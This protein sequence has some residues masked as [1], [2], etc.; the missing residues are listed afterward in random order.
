MA[1]KFKIFSDI[2]DDDIE[3]PKVCYMYFEVDEKEFIIMG[4]FSTYELAYKYARRVHMGCVDRIIIV[5]G[6][7]LSQKIYILRKYPK[8]DIVDI[9]WTHTG[10]YCDIVVGLTNLGGYI[11][12]NINALEYHE[13]GWEN[14]GKYPDRFK[15]IIDEKFTFTKINP[16]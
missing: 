4:L 16:V 3:I 8:K 11:S 14:F 9:V 13:N 12:N 5:P 7:D 15:E 10:E 2:S 6:L 1:Q